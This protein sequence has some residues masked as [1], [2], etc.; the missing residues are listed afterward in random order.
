M[1]LQLLLLEHTR[2]H[3]HTQ[4][5]TPHR[6]ERP[7]AGHFNTEHH[8][9]ASTSA[10]AATSFQHPRQAEDEKW[11]SPLFIRANPS[12]SS[13]SLPPPPGSRLSL[14][15][16]S[17]SHSPM[18]MLCDRTAGLLYA[19]WW[20]GVLL[21]VATSTSLSHYISSPPSAFLSVAPLLSPS[22]HL[23]HRDRCK[24]AL[25]FPPS[26]VSLPPS[27][28]LPCPSISFLLVSRTSPYTSPL[29]F[30]HR[31]DYNCTKALWACQWRK[32]TSVTGE[33]QGAPKSWILSPF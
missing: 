23:K 24:H 18:P 11:S 29:L 4:E 17:R 26:S 12:S 30:I 22:L 6:A 2:T 15:S 14:L 31:T 3:S 27:T 10:P 5:P 7:D 21:H 1:Q 19:A 20:S 28:I 13:F 16:F 33:Q 32:G 25:S 9:P 8:R